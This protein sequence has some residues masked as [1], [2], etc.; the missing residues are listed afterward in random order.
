MA[1]DNS[2]SLSTPFQCADRRE[3]V[4]DAKSSSDDS[5]ETIASLDES[6]SHSFAT[7]SPTNQI[8]ASACIRNNADQSAHDVHMT[9][10]TQRLDFVNIK[11]RDNDVDKKLPTFEDLCMKDTKT[12]NTNVLAADVDDDV[13]AIDSQKYHKPDNT[14]RLQ[15]GDAGGDDLQVLNDDELVGDEAAAVE[16]AAKGGSGEEMKASDMLKLSSIKETN[17]LAN[18]RP[19]FADDSCDGGGA[20]GGGG[21]GKKMFSEVCAEGDEELIQIKRIKI[22]EQY[23]DWLNSA[24]AHGKDKN[25][26]MQEM[27]KINTDRNAFFEGSKGLTAA[28]ESKHEK[29]MMSPRQVDVMAAVT[30]SKTA[31]QRLDDVKA[32]ACQAMEDDSQIMNNVRLTVS[33]QYFAFLTRTCFYI[34]KFYVPF[35]CA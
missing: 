13:M 31:T 16:M 35:S 33:N 18:Q 7:C 9:N 25:V 3:V 10:N 20:G 19:K 30:S 12:L 11:L 2:H 6:Q 15:E 22:D 32:A 28:V 1:Q 14:N 8:A 29:G 24:H 4:C 27:L 34:Y 17:F 5:N 23:S 26:R 21:G